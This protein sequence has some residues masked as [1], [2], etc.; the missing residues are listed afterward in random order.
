MEPSDAITSPT[1]VRPP[2]VHDAH[3]TTLEQLEEPSDDTGNTPAA[4]S[5]R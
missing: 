2:V 4:D 3:H 1:D 5:E